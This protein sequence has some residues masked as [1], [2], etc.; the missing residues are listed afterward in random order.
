MPGSRHFCLASELNAKL[1]VTCLSTHCP[2]CKNF[3][4]IFAL[5][6]NKATWEYNYHEHHQHHHHRW[7]HGQSEILSHSCSRATIVSPSSSLVITH[8]TLGVRYV[9]YMASMTADDP[10]IT[11][12]LHLLAI[13]AFIRQLLIRWN[14]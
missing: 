11:L 13:V 3:V 2:D 10:A 1:D 5:V 14:V 4:F 6:F 12:H 8:I 7:Q 9:S